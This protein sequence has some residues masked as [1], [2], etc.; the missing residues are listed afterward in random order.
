MKLEESEWSRL[1]NLTTS[2]LL[3]QRDGSDLAQ[4]LDSNSYK[5]LP[6]LKIVKE[7]VQHRNKSAVPA[8][9]TGLLQRKFAIFTGVVREQ[10]GNMIYGAGATADVYKAELLSRDGSTLV[11]LKRERAS[12]MPKEE[13]I[14]V[15]LYEKS[16]SSFH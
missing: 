14:D 1:D 12:T 16:I 7:E 8:F 13:E 15:S 2:L 6:L 9:Y 5:H 10:S 11:A 3:E 4:E